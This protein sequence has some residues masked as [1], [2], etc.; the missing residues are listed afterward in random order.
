LDSFSA[1]RPTWSLSELCANLDI[2]KSTLHRFLVSLETHGILRRD[3]DDR[4]WR[5]GY[6]LVTWGGLVEKVTV[7]NDIARPIMREIAIETGEM[8]VLTVVTDQ[9]VVCIEKIDTRQAVRLALEVGARRPLH[10]GA[11]SKILMAYLPPAQVERIVQEQGLPRLCDNTI[12]DPQELYRE[13]AC[14]REQGYA[15]SLEETDAGAWGIAVPIFDRQDNVV[16]ALG[17]AGPTQRYSEQ[18]VQRYV[19]LCRDAALQTSDLLGA[20]PADTAPT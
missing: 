20:G 3:P 1:D 16:A 17:V 15:F 12:T 18:L 2:P 8:V 14:I 7:L 11:S 9:E 6:R 4:H 10:A 5:L 19:S 13:L